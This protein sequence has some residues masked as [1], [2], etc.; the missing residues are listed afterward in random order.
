MKPAGEFR[1]RCEGGS[2]AELVHERSIDHSG[3]AQ[4]YAVRHDPS[5]T[6]FSSTLAETTG[7]HGR[8]DFVLT[9][10]AIC[11]N[12]RQPVTEKTLVGPK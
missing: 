10:L 5:D 4:H 7:K 3:G 6:R 1:S 12:C 9:E 8:Y 2:E 11:P